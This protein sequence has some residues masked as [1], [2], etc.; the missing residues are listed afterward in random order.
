M[1]PNAVTQYI[2]S[3]PQESQVVLAR[4]NGASQHPAELVAEE[5]YVLMARHAALVDKKFLE[6]LSVSELQELEQIRARMEEFDAPFYEPI[7][8]RLTAMLERQTATN[9]FERWICNEFERS[10]I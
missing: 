2:E 3:L 9:S 4:Q 1:E 5:E 8:E 10:N 6:G 7:I